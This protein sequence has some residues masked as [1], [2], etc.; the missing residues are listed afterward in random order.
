M[1]NLLIDLETFVLMTL[2]VAVIT[3]QEVSRCCDGAGLAYA[4]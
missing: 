4:F 3:L 2:A 1:T